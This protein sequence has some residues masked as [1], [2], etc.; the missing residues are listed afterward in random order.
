MRLKIYKFKVYQLLQF[1]MVFM[2]VIILFR[3]LIVYAIID[4]AIYKAFKVCSNPGKASCIINLEVVLTFILSV[5]FLRSSIEP[6]SI[7]GMI[8]MLTGGYF[9]SY[10]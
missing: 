6:R 3:I 8:M 9:I 2:R 5:I 1:Y 7:I 4:P 10:K